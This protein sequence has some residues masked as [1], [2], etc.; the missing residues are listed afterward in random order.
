MPFHAR[1]A[2]FG[3]AA[4]L[5]W[6]FAA[7]LALIGGPSAYAVPLTTSLATPLATALTTPPTTPLTT[8]V[9]EDRLTVPV[10]AEPDG[11][12]VS[13]DIAIWRPQSGGPHPAVLLAHGFG[14]SVADLATQGRTLAERGYLALGYSARGFGASGG[15]IHLDDPD[16]EVADARALVDLLAARDDVLRDAAGDPRVGAVGASYGGALALMLGA[17][18][19]R[20]DSVAA[21][22]TWH[23]LADAFFP[24]VT[25][26]P[27]RIT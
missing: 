23:D 1:G 10:K 24:P 11:I 5:I 8:S 15:R 6:V 9:T 7:M 14:G 2:G 27:S 16:F 25:R 13:L 20:V 19:P 18:D 21:F 22:I 26:A 4:V 3:A 17:T 12:P